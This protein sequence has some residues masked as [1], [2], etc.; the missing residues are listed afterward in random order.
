M[1]KRIM[2]PPMV[3]SPKF[4]VRILL[5][6][7]LPSVEHSPVESPKVLLTTDDDGC[8]FSRRGFGIYKPIRIPTDKNGDRSSTSLN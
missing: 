3:T 7:V 6:L 1:A 4:L 8:P 5:P 2:C